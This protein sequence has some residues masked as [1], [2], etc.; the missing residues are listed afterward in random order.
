LNKRSACGG[1]R[2]ENPMRNG[3]S[4]TRISCDGG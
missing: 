4:L 3:Y 2:V 1:W